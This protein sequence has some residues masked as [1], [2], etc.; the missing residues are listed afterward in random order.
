MKRKDVL[1]HLKIAGYH[2]DSTA[3][4]RLYSENRISRE[5]AN[6][7][8]QYGFRAKKNGMTCTCFRCAK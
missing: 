2:E 4:C 1:G 3:F 5:K 8:Y 7:A 6:E